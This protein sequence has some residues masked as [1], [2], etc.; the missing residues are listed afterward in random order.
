V[1]Q[2]LYSN[3]K[4][5]TILS[6]FAI[7]LFQNLQVPGQLFHVIHTLLQSYINFPRAFINDTNYGPFQKKHHPTIEIH[8]PTIE[9]HQ[10]PLY[11]VCLLF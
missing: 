5:Q 8:H 2:T 10:M 6:Y 4:I 11:C 7:Q 3:E 1:Y 9:K